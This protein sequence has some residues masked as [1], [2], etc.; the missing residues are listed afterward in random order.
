MSIN[1]GGGELKELK[2]RYWCWELVE[3]E[4]MPLML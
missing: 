2:P 3:Q 1:I 4:E